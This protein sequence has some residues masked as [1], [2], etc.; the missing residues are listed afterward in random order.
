MKPEFRGMFTD[1]YFEAV[2]G[3]A[4]KCLESGGSFRLISYGRE[5]ESLPSFTLERSWKGLFTDRQ[6]V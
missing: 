5:S 4:T 2:N 3:T 1:L 6:E